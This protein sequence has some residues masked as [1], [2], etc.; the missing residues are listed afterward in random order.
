MAVKPYL[1]LLAFFFWHEYRRGR[2]QLSRPKPAARH[3][4]VA[5]CPVTTYLSIKT[6]IEHSFV[7]IL[8]QMVRVGRQREKCLRE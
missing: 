8:H 4:T 1:Q 2:Y 7:I 5:P 6:I 3:R